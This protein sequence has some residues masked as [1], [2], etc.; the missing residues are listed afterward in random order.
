MLGFGIYILTLMYLK[1]HAMKEE[2][3]SWA[4]E[5]TSILTIDLC[6]AIRNYKFVR[7]KISKKYWRNYAKHH[8]CKF[9]RPTRLIRFIN[10]RDNN[11]NSETL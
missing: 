8:K 6:P 1:L 4:H 3:E 2:I 10:T 7:L 5:Y 9:I 11:T